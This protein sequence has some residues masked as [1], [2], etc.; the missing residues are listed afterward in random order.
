[1]L[2]PSIVDTLLALKIR[3]G[4][5]S[6]KQVY[7]PSLIFNF[8][9]MR[10]IGFALYANELALLGLFS[11][12][13]FIANFPEMKRVTSRIILSVMLVGLILS[14]SR[15]ILLTYI[16]V[17]GA[18]ATIRPRGSIGNK[19]GVLIRIGVVLATISICAILVP[20]LWS[21]TQSRLDELTAARVG[22][23][24]DLRE[25]SYTRGLQI[26]ADNPFTGIG[27]LPH[28]G[29][30]QIGS[31]SLPLSIAVRIGIIG[32]M[33]LV[34]L[35]LVAMRLALWAVFANNASTARLGAV[36]IIGVISSITIQFD[37]DVLS[38]VGFMLVLAEI[39]RRT[40]ERPARIRE[41]NEVKE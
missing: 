33:A 2:A 36:T 34:F 39:G 19:Y 3:S 12:G 41:P 24:A 8:E 26:F 17:V 15:S 28:D 37:D 21:K 40:L 6:S 16:V 1:M 38:I 27:G 18:V 35:L 4:L 20:G 9:I 32:L 30:I 5:S 25:L 7:T 22:G 29:P 31:H 23:S 13:L 14:T 10:P 11:T